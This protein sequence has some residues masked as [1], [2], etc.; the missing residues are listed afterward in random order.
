M[1]HLIDLS[2]EE[3]RN[4]NGGCISFDIGWLIG[5]GLSGSYNPMTGFSGKAI[6]EYVQHQTTH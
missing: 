2:K 4:I 6:G 5:A 1:K 3:K